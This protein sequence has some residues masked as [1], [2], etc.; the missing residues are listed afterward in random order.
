VVRERA[1]GRDVAELYAL[2]GVITGVLLALAVLCRG[3]LLLLLLGEII[4]FVF[5]WHFKRLRV[6]THGRG[7]RAIYAE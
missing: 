4:R 5:V 6:A 2:G 1:E 7:A 3:V